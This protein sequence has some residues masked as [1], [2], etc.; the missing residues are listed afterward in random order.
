[1][2]DLISTSHTLE[3]EVIELTDKIAA[4]GEFVANL[5]AHKDTKK[6]PKPSI[7]AA[8]ATPPNS[9]ATYQQKEAI[10][11][12]IYFLQINPKSV[13]YLYDHLT[14]LLNNHLI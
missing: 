1:L 5:R 11:E 3:L 2:E 9:V 6:K 10:G 14:S 13:A 8:S 12:A 4:T 7:S